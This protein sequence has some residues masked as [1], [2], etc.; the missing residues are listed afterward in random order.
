MDT[1]S[2]DTLINRWA[3]EKNKQIQISRYRVSLHKLESCI[4]NW[5][6]AFSIGIMQQTVSQR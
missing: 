2:P 5:N 4:L 3:L 1:P 6:H